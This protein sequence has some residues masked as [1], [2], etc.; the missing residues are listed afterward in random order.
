M[1]RYGFSLIELLV[2]IAIIGIIATI[3]YVALGGVREK[4][5]DTKRKSDIAQIGRFLALSCYLPTGGGG[6]YDLADLVT[7]LKATY[8]QYQTFLAQVPQ[9]PKSGSDSQTNYTYAVTADGKKCTLYANLENPDEPITLPSLTAPTP[10]G[11]QGVLH[12]DSP[13]VNDSP[14]YFQYTN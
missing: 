5:R 1:K 3:A 12:A 7:E 8:P 10:G 13:G 14:I 2:T 11:G 4:S 6:T 9:D